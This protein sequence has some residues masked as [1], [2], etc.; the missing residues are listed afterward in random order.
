M[1]PP[2]TNSDWF[3]EISQEG[4][5]AFSL[6]LHSKL[7]E[8]QSPYQKIEVYKTK[9]FGNLLVIDGFVM[10]S[11]RDN[12]IYH[13][14]MAH[15]VLFSHHSPRHVAIIGGGDC[16]T[17]KEVAK[18]SCVEK[19]TQ[20]E[21]DERVTRLSEKYFPDL[22]TANSDSRV[23][24]E[25]QDAINWMQNAPNQDIDIIIIDS[26]DPIGPAEGL[27][28]KEFYSSC[29]NALTADGLIIQQSESPLVHWDSITQPMHAEMQSAGFEQTKTLFFPVPVYPTGWWSATM[30]AKNDIHLVRDTDAKNLG[31]DTKYYNYDVHLSAFAKPTFLQSTTQD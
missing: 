9:H 14:M 20:I 2:A 24:F 17:L 5:T 10:L 13:E 19:I 30:A 16:G 7:H 23:L 4:G 22:C 6:K 11:E 1:N 29:L 8:E 18:H 27:F 21:I 25:F 26:T 28:Q 31:F 15:T 3:T 12:F